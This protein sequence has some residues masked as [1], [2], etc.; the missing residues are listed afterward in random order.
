MGKRRPSQ[1][2]QQL[3]IP[4]TGH[5]PYQDGAAIAFGCF[6]HEA[7]PKCALKLILGPAVEHAAAAQRDRNK[8]DTKWHASASDGGG[9]GD[10]PPSCYYHWGHQKPTNSHV[11]T[12]R[13]SFAHSLTPAYFSGYFPLPAERLAH[14]HLIRSCQL[15]PGSESLTCL[16]AD[17]LRVRVAILSGPVLFPDRNQVTQ[18]TSTMAGDFRAGGW[19]K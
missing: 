11:A 10:I 18:H 14:P 8:E 15:D 4:P 5:L 3:G 19:S 1:G 12:V 7:G 9:Q 17:W 16:Q 6:K 2:N 13:V